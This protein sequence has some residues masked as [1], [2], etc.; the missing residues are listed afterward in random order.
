MEIPGSVGE[1]K[2]EQSSHLAGGEAEEEV[3]G[4]V[5]ELHHGHEEPGAIL[6]G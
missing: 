3:S 2:I 4:V 6:Q 5:L 1:S